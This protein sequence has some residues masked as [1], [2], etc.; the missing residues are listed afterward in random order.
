MIG[1][2]SRL[3]GQMDRFR[4]GDGPP[5]IE[6]SRTGCINDFRKTCLMCEEAKVPPDEVTFRELRQIVVDRLKDNR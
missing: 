2:I 1:H 6:L 3:Y 5:T 4:V